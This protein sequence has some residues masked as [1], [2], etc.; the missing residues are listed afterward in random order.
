MKKILSKILFKLKS[1]IKVSV[2]EIAN[3]FVLLR[4]NVGLPISSIIKKNKNK[5]IMKKVIKK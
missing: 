2:I 5:R 1:N 4:I 3:F